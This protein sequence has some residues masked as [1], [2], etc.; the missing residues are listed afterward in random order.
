MRKYALL[1]VSLLSAAACTGDVPTTP[2]PASASTRATTHRGYYPG[3]R[4]LDLIEAGKLTP[5]NCV[6]RVSSQGSALIGP[7]GGTLWIGRHRL[8]VPAGA[9]TK[10][11]LISGTV[12]EGRPF[13]IDLQPHGLEFRKAAGLLLD[14]SSCTDVPTIVYLVDQYSVSPPIAAIYSNW[15]RMI[16]CP[17]WH[18]SG[19]AIA[20]GDGRATGEIE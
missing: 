1:A 4:M 7:A 5:I 20:L 11:V 3:S 14:A 6:P 9:L 12:P 18:F 15:W 17:I 19:Y 13:E 8:I 2:A 10:K 16:A